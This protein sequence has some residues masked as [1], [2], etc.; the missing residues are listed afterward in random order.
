MKYGVGITTQQFQDDQNKWVDKICITFPWIRKA[1]DI[2]STSEAA[3]KAISSDGLKEDSYITERVKC[4]ALE[5][6]GLQRLLPRGGPWGFFGWHLVRDTHKEVI[7]TEGEYDAMAVAQALEDIEDPNHPLKDIPAI[8]L[9][10]G[11]SSLPIE[12]LP[13]LDRFKKVYLWLDNDKPGI[14]N[15]EKIARKIGLLRCYVVR[16]DSSMVNPPKDA[17]DALRQSVEDLIPSLLSQAQILSHHKLLSFADMKDDILRLVRS[18]RPIIGT[19]T[20][21]LPKLTSICKGFRRGELVIFTG[22]TGTGK[23]TLLS[24][25]SLDFAKQV[26]IYLS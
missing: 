4:R 5:T 20:P 13:Q 6:K 16:P 25:L 10:N 2:L 26:G 12:L 23:T 7:I 19:S 9:P 15:S 21:S 11:C 8:S 18:D 17:N 24:Q 3:A 22:P 14:D 1:S